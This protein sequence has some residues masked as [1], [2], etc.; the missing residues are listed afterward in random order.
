MTFSLGLP[1]TAS[2]EPG[3]PWLRMHWAWAI[4]A[5]FRLAVTAG[6]PCGETIAESSPW[7]ASCAAWNAGDWVSMLDG[8]LM[9]PIELY[10]PLMLEPGSGK[11]GS[12]CARM[13]FANS[14]AAT[15]RDVAVRVGK[16]LPHSAASRPIGSLAPLWLFYSATG[17]SAVTAS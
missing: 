5:A 16:L 10:G 3:T 2:G 17:N 8:T 7:H 11:S 12:P 6:L 4:S 9:P 14:R 15:V 1:A 13:H